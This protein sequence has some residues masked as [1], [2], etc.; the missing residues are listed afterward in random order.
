MLVLAA[1]AALCVA[2]PCQLLAVAQP[3]LAMYAAS[4]V[5]AQALPLIHA[6]L[7]LADPPQKLA[8]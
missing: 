7:Q 1:A 8:A 6:A 4:L 5:G 2:R 3:L